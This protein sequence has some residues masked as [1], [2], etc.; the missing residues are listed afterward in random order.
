ML[1]LLCLIPPLAVLV[2]GRPIQAILN[3]LLTLAFYI[4]GVI[5]AVL[6]VNEH[7]ADKRMKKYAK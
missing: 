5:H 6:V 3:F 1:Y 2:T 7:K 4:P